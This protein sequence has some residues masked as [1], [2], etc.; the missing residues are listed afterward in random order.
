MRS[1][2]KAPWFAVGSVCLGAFMGQLDA[3]IVTL[4]FPSLRTDFHAHL[5]SVQWVSLSYL[6]VLAVLL[7]PVGRFSD[8]HGRKLLYVWG[9]VVFTLA[10][11]ACGFAPSLGWLVAGRVVQALGAALLQANSVALVVGSVGPE[12]ARTALGIQAA[13][14]AMGLAAGPAIGGALVGLFG[15]RSVFL[16]NLPVGVVAVVAGL[17]L[18]PR[19][20][21]RHAGQGSDL[22]GNVLLAVTVLASLWTFSLLAESHV[23]TVEV[24]GFAV[25]SVLAGWLFWRTESRASAPLVPPARLRTRGVGVGL[26]GALL[27]YLVLFAPLVL[28]P[29]VFAQWGLSTGQG[30]LVLTCL[31]AGFAIAAVVGGRVGHHIGN[32]PRVLVGSLV[33]VAALIGQAVWWHLPVVVAVLLIVMGMSLGI[34]LP[35]NNAMVMTAVPASAS[36]VTGGMINVSRAAGTSMGVAITSIGVEVATSHSWPEAPIVVSVLALAALAMAAT[37][38]RG[39]SDHSTTES[40]EL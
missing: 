4:A 10:S 17:L 29:L 13:A 22:A 1:H 5:A 23:R 14:Q 19:T 24:V 20:H 8:I 11:A 7:I 2:P 30:G 32:G 33:G 28:Y 31:P 35:A 27:G 16:I 18:L 15:W 3:S 12:R 9:F 6:A 26:V 36:A 39:A 37:G 25:L 34:V 38:R 40:F 21:E